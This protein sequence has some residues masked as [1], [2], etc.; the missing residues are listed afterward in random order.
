MKAKRVLLGTLAMGV[1]ALCGNALAGSANTNLSVS[2]SV[3]ANCTITTNA[4]AFGAYDPVSTNAAAGADLTNGTAGSINLTCTKGSSGVNV[5][6]GLGGHASG[7]TRRMLGGTSGDFLTYELYQPA[8]ATPWTCTFP[9]TTVWGT[10]GANIYTPTGVTWSAAAAQ[11]FKVC[12][13]VVKNQNVSADA[14]YT[15]TV[16]ATVNF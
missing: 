6:L 2:A 15:D 8:T 13:T 14:S 16:V 9:G 5:T 10:A 4:V 12:G 3:A 11:S 1:G 7:T